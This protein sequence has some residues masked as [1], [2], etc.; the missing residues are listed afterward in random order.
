LTRD[1][2]SR[3]T[4]SSRK[5]A[6]AFVSRLNRKFVMN[7][8]LLTMNNF[9]KKFEDERNYEEKWKSYDFINQFTCLRKAQ[10]L[11]EWLSIAFDEQ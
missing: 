8:R 2:R 7:K 10:L 3:L 1:L 9:Q 5:E 6:E 4:T 11:N